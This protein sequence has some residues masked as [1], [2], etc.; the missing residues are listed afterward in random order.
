MVARHWR[1]P[2]LNSKRTSKS[3]HSRSSP[4]LQFSSQVHPAHQCR[5][6]P[7]LSPSASSIPRQHVTTSCPFPARISRLGS[8][9]APFWH[10]CAQSPPPL[11]SIVR[12]PS[13]PQPAPQSRGCVRATLA[14]QYAMW[15]ALSELS[16]SI[17]VF[18]ER[19]HPN[20]SVR[21][22]VPHQPRHSC[23]GRIRIQK[24]RVTAVPGLSTVAWMIIVSDG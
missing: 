6:P 14:C 10:L 3:K 23:T 9:T 22:S 17:N 7:L 19:L 11:R 5:P 24:A 21:R 16:Q 1:D 15:S 18:L 12:R 20:F 2:S 8:D 13:G 4:G